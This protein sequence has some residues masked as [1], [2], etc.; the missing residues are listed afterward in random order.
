[1]RRLGEEAGGFDWKAEQERVQRAL[2]NLWQRN[3]WNDEADRFAFDLARD[4][5]A[6]PPW[7]LTGRFDLVADRIAQRYGFSGRSAARFRELVYREAGGLLTRNARVILK[8]TQE[9]VQMRS[10]SRP[11]TA[12]QVARWIRES[13]PLITD[14]RE[15]I[16][17]AVAELEPTL[18]D[19]Q[20]T[21][22]E[23]D[24]ESLRKRMEVMDQDFP[25]W[26]KGEWQAADWGMEDDPIQS[27]AK[28]VPSPVRTQETA[29]V[30]AAA[31][32]PTRWVAEEPATWVGYVVD[33]VH[34]FELDGGQVTAAESIHTELLERAS[35]YC[36]RNAE[37]LSAVAS[38]ERRT[39]EAYEPLRVLFGELRERLDA[40]PTTEQ[41]D[42]HGRQPSVA[43]EVSTV[44]PTTVPAVQP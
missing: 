25:R 43:S 14:L 27:A 4:I 7:H 12:G 13:E 20:R 31:A 23:R 36:E 17:R 41:R 33:F 2:T 22:L 42:Q 10:Q 1:M 28:P 35:A 15:T 3:N 34:R 37:R 18:S 24:R 32:A 5:S 30:V 26:A 38:S 29:A 6:I 11:F 8:Q 9:F 39:H 40:I 21:L 16:D 19:P 44:V